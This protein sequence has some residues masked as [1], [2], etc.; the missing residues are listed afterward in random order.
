MCD[1]CESCDS[2]L[3]VTCDVKAVFVCGWHNLSRVIRSARAVNFEFQFAIWHISHLPM[4]LF[5]VHTLQRV[6]GAPISAP[7]PSTIAHK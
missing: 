3:A 2:S 6:A 5:C 1:G 4:A 7:T